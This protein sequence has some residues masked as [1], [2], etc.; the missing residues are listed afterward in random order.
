LFLLIATI[1]WVLFWYWDTA[2]A[3]VAIWARSD[4]YAHAFIV[5]PITLWLIWRKRHELA[6]LNPEPTLWMVL[7]IL[8]T[9]VFWLMGE[10][11]AVNALTQFALVATLIL[12]I[13]STLGISVCRQIAF[14]LAFLLLSVPFGDFMMPKL[15]EWTAWFAVL[16]LRAS[17]I[18]VYQEGLQFVI[19][20][21]NWSVV[22]ACS[23]IRYIIASVTV[24]TLFAY[25]NYVTLRRR[26]I[27]IAISFIVPVVA[28]WLRAYMIVMI[29]H[30]SS[31]KLAVGVDHLIYG[32]VFFGLVIMAMFA[33]GA[34]W[35]EHAPTETHSA[36]AQPAG[37]RNGFSS[38]LV[39]TAI[40]VLTASGPLAYLAITNA[41]K[42]AP[43]TLGSLKTPP[44]WSPAPAFTAW[45]PA[46]ENPSV[47][48][49]A[50]FDDGT[51][52]VGVYVAYYRSQNYGRKLITSTNTLVTSNDRTWSVISRST[53]QVALQDLPLPVR[54]AEILSKESGIESRIA[55]WQ[56]YWINGRLTSSDI[57]AKWLTALSRF[58][59]QGDDSAVVML[60][61]PSGRSPERLSDFAA[62]AGPQI[63]QLLAATREAR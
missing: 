24:G 30:L 44:G 58:R 42:A 4:T 25:L 18:P 38:W 14:P 5:P 2:R 33:I 21:G 19:P 28:N 20:S 49:Q 1:G 45:T 37:T 48:I 62:A 8:A 6:R 63:Q 55:V 57:E 41:D 60:Y 17:G 56:W 34:R 61:A 54:T 47:T 3:M 53:L 27:F 52:P 7:P 15:M 40:A 46:Y 23:G 29:G 43:A 26:L 39:M 22:E 16:A 10:L 51:G 50:T 13:I 11:T 9:T 32:W 31:N 59:G 12:T 35:S 36:M